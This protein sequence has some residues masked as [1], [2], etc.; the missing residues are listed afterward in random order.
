MK[1]HLI[2][3]IIIISNNLYSQYFFSKQDSNGYVL[4]SKDASCTYCVCNNCNGKGKYLKDFWI[5]C[6]NCKDWAS[7]YRN[8]RGCDV[9]KNKKG[10]YES[11][12]TQCEPC[13]G[14]GQFHNTYLEDHSIKK[15]DYSNCNIFKSKIDKAA[16]PTKLEVAEG[17][18]G[19]TIENWRFD[20]LD[21]FGTITIKDYAGIKDVNCSDIQECSYTVDVYLTLQDT[22]TKKRYTCNMKLKF[23]F[24]DNKW[25]FNKIISGGVQEN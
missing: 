14:K 25:V 13:A 4:I 2:Y 15:E 7:S 8:A 3:L 11:R 6:Y 19:Q 22:K 21:D 18:L 12:L 17:L 5:P 9:C 23:K 1:K 24:L 20:S 10:K 16:N